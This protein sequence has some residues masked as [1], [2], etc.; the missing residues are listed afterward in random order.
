MVNVVLTDGEEDAHVGRPKRNLKPSAALLSAD[1]LND[2]EKVI[3]PSQQQA[4]KT[5]RA[6]EAA[7]RAAEIKLAIEAEAANATPSPSSRDSSP[8]TPS[9]STVTGSVPSTLHS[10]H[11]SKKRVYVS[12]EEESDDEREDARGNP[13][14]PGTVF[15]FR[16]VV[17]LT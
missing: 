2:P 12:E 11:Q 10:S 1:L 15:S 6:A 13:R 8:V 7:R 16:R 14:P 17:L 5:F 9:R 4:I 3:L